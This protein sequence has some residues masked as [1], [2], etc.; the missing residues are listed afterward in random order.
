ELRYEE[1]KTSQLVLDEL[2]SMG[3]QAFRVAGTGVVGLVKGRG[4]GDV[5]ALRADMDALPIQEEGDVPYKSRVAGKMHACGHDAHVAMLLGAAKV[6]SKF[7]DS[8]RG[9]VKLIFQ[10][11]EEGGAGAERIIREGV[12]DDVKAIYGIHVWAELP[13][14]VI[15]TRKGAM[16]ASATSFMI[17]IKGLGGHAAHP[18]LTKDPTTPAVDIYNALQKV[19][20][21]N[22][23]PFTP[24][25]I[26]TP[27]LEGSNASNVI[28]D[29]AKIYGT[30]RT[31]DLS[32]RDQVLR[33]MEAIVKHYS[34][35]WDCVGTLEVTD[36]SYPP[37]IN[38]AE[39]ADFV[40]SVAKKLGEVREAPMS[41]GAEDFSYYLQKVKG[42]F[43]ILGIKNEGKG[44]IYPHHHPKFDVDEEVLW[45]GTALHALLAYNQLK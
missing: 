11:A 23:D 42:A 1:F 33:R 7:R 29:E 36:V 44:I 35:A 19:V 10:P 37:V 15:A 14:G 21:R 40:L 6:L 22:V 2:T 5:I 43:I 25:V 20:S 12:L 16:N 45:K 26:S 31:F 13:S 3:V 32:L 17:R 41:M 34:L 38:D 39:H 9:A 8:F 30:L 4:E 18:E 28:P 24:I 27:R